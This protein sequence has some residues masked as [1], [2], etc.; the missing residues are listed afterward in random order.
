MR[1][2]E[3]AQA[4]G[5]LAAADVDVAVHEVGPELDALQVVFHE[6]LQLNRRGAEKTT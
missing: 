4:L 6:L 5:Y 3:A 2:D 1:R